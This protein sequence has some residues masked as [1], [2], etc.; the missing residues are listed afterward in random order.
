MKV[1][2]NLGKPVMM[3]CRKN[4][5]WYLLL[6]GNDTVPISLWCGRVMRYVLYGVL[7]TPWAIRGAN[8]FLF[9]TSSKIGGF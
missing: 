8:L 7:S 2:I 5:G 9:V 6:A 1:K 4:L 3:Q